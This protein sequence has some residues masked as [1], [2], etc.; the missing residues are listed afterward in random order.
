[1]PRRLVAVL[2]VVAALVLATHAMPAVAQTPPASRGLIRGSD[3]PPGWALEST[4]ADGATDAVHD[5]CG[6]GPPIASLSSAMITYRRDDSDAI[7]MQSVMVFA[8]GDA[9][10]A[11]AYL[12]ADYSECDGTRTTG[13]GFVPLPFP[14][15][16]DETIS[17]QGEIPGADRRTGIGIALIHDGD[18]II[19]I[20]KIGDLEAGPLD[21]ELMEHVARLTLE[22]LRAE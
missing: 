14:T 19:F 16:G 1:M 7:L 13:P 10:A 15:F 12:R 6:G 22:R 2:A 18:A 9:A 17:V 21:T 5:E 3:L 8:P 4:S 11:M 20:E